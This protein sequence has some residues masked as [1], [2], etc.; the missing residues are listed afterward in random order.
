MMVVGH[1]GVGKSATAN[2][3]LGKE[4]FRETETKRCELQSIRVEGRNVSVI[5]TPGMNNTSLTTEEWKTELRRGLLLSSPGP[6]VFLLVTKVGKFS[7]EERNAVKWIRENFGEVALKFTMILFIGREEMANRQW[8]TFSEDPWTKDL[9]R[10]CEGRYC[11]IN[12]KREANPAQIAVLLEE[13]EAMVQQNGDRFYT[14]EMYEVVNGMRMT[15]LRQEK[16]KMIKGQKPN[17]DKDPDVKK[18]DAVIGVNIKCGNVIPTEKQ[19]EAVKSHSQRRGEMKAYSDIFRKQEET[20]REMEKKKWK[21]E[22][23]ATEGVKHDPGEFSTFASY[24][25]LPD[26]K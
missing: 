12:S 11:A 15:E 16:E 4:T 24:N 22:R 17:Q 2:T 26:T 6:H 10:C 23:K 9:I 25:P 18:D 1:C 7:E 5:D 20:Q 14:Q 19:E 3:I 13:I 21:E 8:V